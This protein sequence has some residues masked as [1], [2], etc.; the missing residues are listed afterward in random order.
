MKQFAKCK[1]S[2]LILSL[3]FLQITSFTQYPIGLKKVAA[4]FSTSIPL[5]YDIQ[6]W[7]SGFT[8]CETET[9]TDLPV[10]FPIDIDGTYFRNGYAKFEVG[11]DL[12]MHPFDAD[13]MITAIQVSNGTGVFRNRFVNTDGYVRERKTKRVSYRGIFGTAKKGGVLSNIFD[14][15]LK[16]VANTN[17]LYSSGRLLA[18][19]EGGLPHLM[20]PDSLRTIGQYRFRGNL[21]PK[22]VCTAHPRYDSITDR[23]II[24]SEKRNMLKGSTVVTIQEFDKNLTIVKKR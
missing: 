15:K 8:T 23:N 22:D 17:V 16:N 10:E 14:T 7:R 4:I 20:E 13:G 24:F 5:T 18:L 9:C 12:I 11:K 21:D 3:L 19:W 6:A 1:Y 2:L